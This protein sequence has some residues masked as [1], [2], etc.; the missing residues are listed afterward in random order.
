MTQKPTNIH[1]SPPV[2]DPDKAQLAVAMRYSW[3]II[4][5]LMGKVRDL[6]TAISNAETT[7]KNKPPE[8]NNDVYRSL[9]GM[10]D[11]CRQSRKEHSEALEALKATGFR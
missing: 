8:D 10:L 11:H 3:Y 7:L 6:D 1:S 5:A 2:V 4:N 9:A